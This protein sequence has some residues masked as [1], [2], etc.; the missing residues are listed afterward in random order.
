MTGAGFGGC[1]VALVE[2]DRAGEAGARTVEAYERASGRS[3]RF[4]VSTPAAGA[5]SAA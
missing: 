3:G 5:L 2:R 4:W 1:I